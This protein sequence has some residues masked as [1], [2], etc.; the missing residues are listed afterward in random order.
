MVKID[1]HVISHVKSTSPRMQPDDLPRIFAYIGGILRKLG[2]IPLAIGGVSDHIHIVMSLSPNMA[3]SNLMRTI[4]S[5]SS[6]WIKSLSPQYATFAWQ[7]GYGAFSISPSILEKVIQYV[8]NQE[9]H[10]RKRTYEEEYK[11]FLDAYHISYDE[12]YLFN[13]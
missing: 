12:R 5:Y 11:A 4:K 8:K 13:D 6:K 3:L 2:S 1:M 10:H 7:D 9:S